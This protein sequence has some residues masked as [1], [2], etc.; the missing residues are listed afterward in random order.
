MNLTNYIQKNSNY[1][2]TLIL[3]LSSDFLTMDFGPA[4][5]FADDSYPGLLFG[6]P[7]ITGQNSTIF[8]WINN[9]IVDN[10]VGG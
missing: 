1:S 9:A 8:N 5:T 6:S 7:V 10:D 2:D 4:N 3:P